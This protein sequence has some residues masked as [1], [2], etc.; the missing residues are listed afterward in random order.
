LTNAIDPRALSN[1]ASFDHEVFEHRL[2]IGSGRRR[3]KILGDA[4]V[5]LAAESQVRKQVVDDLTSANRKLEAEIDDLK[6]Q[7]KRHN[8]RLDEIQDTREYR[9]LNEEVRYLRRQAEGKEEEVLANL[10]RIEEAEAEWKES[11]NSFES[12][13]AETNSAVAKIAEERSEH[14]AE[15]SRAEKALEQYLTQVG[16]AT[17][18]FYR[19]RVSRQQQPVVWMVKGACGSCH[20]KLTP[21]G[22]LEVLSAKKLVTCGTC[23]RVVVAP[24]AEDSEVH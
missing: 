12:K 1:L 24:L 20:T 18:S 15:L 2:A 5:E 21:Q 7:A 6:S 17:V 16:E 23:G 22:R 10:E 3:E 9:A 8:R 19:R 13:L 14:E 11:K 4:K